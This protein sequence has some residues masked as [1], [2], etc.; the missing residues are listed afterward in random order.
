MNGREKKTNA[1][2]YIFSFLIPVGIAFLAFFNI[3]IYPGSVNTLLIYDMRNELL[4][5]YGYLS[6]PGPGYD[7]L[8]HTMSGSLGYDFL[9]RIA[10]ALSFFDIVYK[11][12]PVELIPDA[13]YFVTLL[14][15]GLCGLCM[16]VFL[17]SRHGKDAGRVWIIFLSS[18]Y[19]LMSYIFIFTSWPLWMDLVMLFPLLALSLERIIAGKKNP[20]FILLLA[21]GLI[22]DYHIAYMTIIALT[23]YF[24]F[25]LAEEGVLL[26]ECIGR[27]VTYIIHGIISAGLCSFMLFPI[28]SDLRLGKMSSSYAAD[29]SLVFIKNTPLDVL[30]SFIPGSYTSLGNNASPNVFCGSLVILLALIWLIYGKKEIRGRMAGAVVVLIYFASFIFGP[31]DRFWHGFRD[32]VGFSVRYSFTLVFFIICFAVRAVTV[33]RRSGLKIS[34]GLRVSVTS[35]LL[36]FSAAEI[37]INGS[38]ILARLSV[39]FGYANK[40]EYSRYNEFMTELIGIA[41]NDSD[42]EYYRLYKDFHYTLYDGALYG[43]DGLLLSDS[44]INPGLVSYLNSIGIGAAPQRNDECGITPPTASLFDFRYFISSSAD[45][46]LYEKIGEYNYHYLYKNKYSLPLIFGTSFDPNGDLREFSDDPFENINIIYS[47]FLGEETGVFVK[48]ECRISY[49][50]EDEYRSEYTAGAADL[51]FTPDD[52]GIFWLYSGFNIVDPRLYEDIDEYGSFSAHVY[53]DVSLNDEVVGYFRDS[54]YS[55]A[56]EIGILEPAEE[57]KVSLETSY[58]ELGNTYIYRYDE[59]ALEKASEALNGNGFDITYIGDKGITAEGE[60][61]EEGYVYISL[62]YD[63]GYTIYVDGKKTD[64]TLY[65]DMFLLVEM[66]EGKHEI[67]IGFIPRGLRTGIVTSL[68]FLVIM[69]IYMRFNANNHFLKK[70][71]VKHP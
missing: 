34:G 32:P 14:K 41:D 30:K 24:F 52:E 61:S 54:N 11:F 48:Q 9:G 66:S 25:R 1:I 53:A 42:G 21:L 31:L 23:L 16:S 26:K 55:Y 39:E 37:Y 22:S 29:S 44:N 3:R 13:I 46:D 40:S 62:P 47:D 7:S 64:H 56:N 5:T 19:A 2:I 60:M 68:I 28:A 15:I 35:I 38:Y 63:P 51:Y 71:T 70:I 17:T 36:L 10:H 27:T 45:C 6:D 57:V 33:L 4:P 18:C 12:V 8:L 58:S 49:P 69:L 20:F 59:D 43:Y 67:S 50:A 65:R